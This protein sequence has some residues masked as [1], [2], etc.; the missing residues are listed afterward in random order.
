MGPIL[1]HQWNSVSAQL[2][3]VGASQTART[4]AN[5]V[6]HVLEFVV[7]DACRK[8]QIMSNPSTFTSWDCR[9]ELNTHFDSQTRDV[10][11]VTVRLQKGRV[12]KKHQNA[13]K[14]PRFVSDLA[15]LD[16]SKLDDG[17]ADE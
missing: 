12:A 11:K 10:R 13:N 3:P 8:W 9:L 14:P 6:K 17:T 16:A 4:T 5:R 2:S 15:L 7:D 1:P